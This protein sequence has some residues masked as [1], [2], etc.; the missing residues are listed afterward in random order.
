MGYKYIYSPRGFVIDFNDKKLLKKFTLE[1]KEY[2][3]RNDKNLNLLYE[4]AKKFGILKI[5]KMHIEILA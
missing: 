3:K 4:Y 2:M 1:L 5:V